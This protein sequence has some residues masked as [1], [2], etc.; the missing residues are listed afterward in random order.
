MAYEKLYSR[1]HEMLGSDEFLAMES[2]LQKNSMFSLVGTTYR[3]RWYSSFIAWLINPA[4]G[5]GLK[6]YPLKRLLSTSLVESL[7]EDRNQHDQKLLPL[8]ENS[9]YENVV[10]MPDNTES[11]GAEK[12][13]KVNGTKCSFDVSASF[14]IDS[15]LVTNNRKVVLLLENKV[16]SNEGDLQTETYAEWDPHFPINGTESVGGI[17]K[18]YVYLTPNGAD[19][20]SSNNFVHLNYQTFYDC[21]ISPCE[22]HPLLTPLGKDLIS[23]FTETLFLSNLALRKSDLSTGKKFIRKYENTIEDMLNILSLNTTENPEGE[24]SYKPRVSLT[25]LVNKS[26]SLSEGTPLSYKRGQVRGEAQ[27]KEVTEE[28]ETEYRLKIE[29]APALFT[30]VAAAAR[31]LQ[32]GRSCNGWNYFTVGTD[33]LSEIRDEIQ[34]ANIKELRMNQANAEPYAKYVKAVFEEH[35]PTFQLLERLLEEEHE[36]FELPYLSHRSRTSYDY[37]LIPSLDEVEV[38]ENGRIKLRCENLTAEVNFNNGKRPA[39]FITESDKPNQS[40][41]AT[42]ATELATQKRQWWADKWFFV[43]GGGSIQG[44][45]V[46]DV[47]ERHILKS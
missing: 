23:E 31:H 34:N 33:G 20:P 1:I 45:S 8:I 43:V 11:V 2:S 25:E 16:K 36:D 30:S 29:D 47:Y 37:S 40:R 9:K 28:G 7:E 38:E 22:R 3:E 44:S 39:F 18:V 12:T 5:H 6:E 26:D 13:V 27:I 21:I 46:K 24:S 15:P 4:S 14:Q 19:S 42:E 41:T 35:L 17:K 10:V 32:N